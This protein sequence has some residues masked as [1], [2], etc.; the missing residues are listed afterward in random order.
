M[1]RDWRVPSGRMFRGAELT[2]L[3]TM[4]LM[5]IVIA[6]I[7]VRL[8]EPD[9]IRAL[10]GL[11]RDGSSPAVAAADPVGPGSPAPAPSD[12][13]RETPPAQTPAPLAADAAKGNAAKSE[14]AKAKAAQADPIKA[15]DAKATATKATQGDAAKTSVPGASAASVSAPKAS[16][17]EKGPAAASSTAAA[18]PEARAAA[19]AAEKKTADSAEPSGPTDQDWEQAEAL[20][21]ELQR[22]SDR[23]LAVQPEEMDAYNRLVYWAENQSSEAMFSRAKK[24]LRFNDFVQS[25]RDHR[26]QLF[27]LEFN[28]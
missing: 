22:V 7:M 17:P 14:A 1:G 8:R 25:P 4:I 27:E 15:T 6:M 3:L 19:G 28:A 11:L 26:G 9:T 21:E 18:G 24:G 16:S 23:T 13:G 10:D 12:K 2:R 5:L 20:R